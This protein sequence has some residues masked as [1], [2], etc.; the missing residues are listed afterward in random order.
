[1]IQQPK[2]PYV[3][4]TC[5]AVESKDVDGHV[6][7]KNKYWANIVPAG[8]KDEVVKDADEW[9]ASLREKG[10]TRGPFDSA[11]NEY[12]VWFE[13]FGD[14]LKRYKAGEEL[15]VTGTPLRAIL[16]FTKAEVAQ[17]ESARI[18]SLEDLSTCNEEGLR[19]IG[20]GGRALKDKAVQL[21]ASRGDNR[22][23][24][25]NSALRVKVEQL[26]ARIEQF[27]AANSQ[28]PKRG[29][30]RPPKQPVEQE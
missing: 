5:E 8:G 24:E 15:A 19:Y 13:H 22:L 4:F 18:Y 20:I 29:P 21:L 1:M 6:Q 10:T 27:I 28:E 30:G 26:E 12:R 16:A 14:A 25:E 11:A 7:Y 17:A 3:R 2:L 9:V 23:A